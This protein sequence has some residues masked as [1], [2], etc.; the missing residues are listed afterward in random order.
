VTAIRVAFTLIGGPRWTGGRMYLTNLLRALESYQS[1]RVQPVLFVGEDIDQADLLPFLQIGNVEIVRSA[2]FNEDRFTA[3]R[4]VA[5]LWG[6][7]REAVDIFSLNRIDV[8]FE[9][10]T[11]YG[12][13]S[14]IPAVAWLPDFQH[15]R[16][17]HHFTLAAYW[18]RETG[19]RAQVA[20]GRQIMLSSEDARKDCEHFYPRSIGRTSVV[21]FASL[22]GREMMESNPAARIPEYGLPSRFVYQSLIHNTEPTRLRCISYAVFC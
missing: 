5:L 18:R 15:C 9:S 2:H 21:R 1:P 3:R 22:I 8:M 13:N 20:S 17:R 19:F 16:L 6:I 7:D 10:A 12:R 11:F 4:A 14:P